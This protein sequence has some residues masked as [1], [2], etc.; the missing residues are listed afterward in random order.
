YHPDATLQDKGF[1]IL[2]ND[3]GS[4]NETH[5]ATPRAVKAAYDLANTASQ[6]ANNANSNAD[7]RLA[8]DQNGA[9][10]PD[11]DTFVNNLGLRDTVNQAEN[12][13]QKSA[14][15]LLAVPIGGILMW[16]SDLPHPNNFLPMEGG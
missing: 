8:K 1:V 2:S 13:L 16:C 9:D 5:A 10:I 6:S 7:T 14:A 11:K 3:V 12:A 4:N 15:E